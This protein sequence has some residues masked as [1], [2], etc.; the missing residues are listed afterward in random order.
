MA[1]LV[2]RVLF[3]YKG[4]AKGKGKGKGKSNN[5]E[6]ADDEEGVGA[7]AAGGDGGGLAELAGRGALLAEDAAPTAGGARR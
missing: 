1:R 2:C 7:A 6:G 5:D 4:I 3:T